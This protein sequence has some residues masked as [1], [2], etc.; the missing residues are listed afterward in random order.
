[1]SLLFSRISNQEKILFT[2]RLAILI[3]AGVP[4]LDSL[5]MLAR[6]TNSRAAAH[7]LGKVVHDV[8]QGQFLST[9]LRQFDKIFGEFAVSIINVGELSGTLQ[10]NLNYLAE[11]LR[12]KQE[13]RRKVIGALVYPAFIVLA[14]IAITVL[15]TVLIF[16]RILPIFASFKFDLPFSTRALIFISGIMLNY[17]IYI[18]IGIAAAIIA[19]ILS[20]R[21]EKF[22]RAGDY[23]TLKI[24]IFGRMSQSYHMANFC[25]TL[26]LLLK[27]Q[28]KIVEALQVTAGTITNRVYR[29]EILAFAE[30]VR[31]GE[32]ISAHLKR[33]EKLFTPIVGQM[34]E[35]GETTGN[36]SET[37]LFVA[38]L[39]E[40][41]LDALTKNLSNMI[42]PVLMIF[43][44]LIVGFVAVS[45]ITP[46]YEVTQ[47]LHP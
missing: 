31:K 18:G 8:E 41:E 40:N 4:I 9:S 43:M 36:L 3:R 23:A 11:E 29:K 19:F 15:L 1:M 34:V 38:E 26:G 7:V 27:S 10:E 42:E 20:L 13:L 30:H 32:K 16:P 46:I 2:K 24:P 45:I 5:R 33:K 39:F 22:R 25:R 35:V 17:G 37:L 21:I 12:K 6:Q 47:H 14:T 44:G 28:I